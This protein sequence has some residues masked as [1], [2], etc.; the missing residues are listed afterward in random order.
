[1]NTTLG[2]IAMTAPVA[3]AIFGFGIG[4]AHA[5]PMEVSEHSQVQP[6]PDWGDA[7]AAD[8]DSDEPEDTPDDEPADPPADEPVDEPADEPVDEPTE[9]DSEEADEETDEETDDEESGVRS[10]P[11]P[12]VETVHT[13]AVSDEESS[14]DG[15]ETLRTTAAELTPPSQDSA[16]VQVPVAFL[17]AGGAIVAGIAAWAGYRRHRIFTS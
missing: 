15:A 17:A 7:F 6:E 8:V 5:A 14:D 13:T 10:R 11:A 4:P 1:M 2:R 3:A 9:D 12:A 16:G